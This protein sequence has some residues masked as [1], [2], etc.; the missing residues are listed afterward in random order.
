V[1]RV[2]I[3]GGTFDPVHTG[4]VVAAV[5]ARDRLGLDRV[6]VVVA[7]D[8]WQK[9]ER[10]LAPAADRFAMV[11]AAFEGLDRVEASDLELHRPGPTYTID[12]VVA[13]ARPDRELYLVLGRDAAVGV[14]SWR[15]APELRD[16]VT[17]AVVE[18]AGS[19][20]TRTVPAGWSTVS[21]TMP[22]LD[23]SSSDLRD[24]V[25]AGQAVDGLVPPGAVRIIRARRL[26]TPA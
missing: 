7:A 15:R 3:F 23:I 10:V 6:L 11:A 22:R 9:A 4:H 24:R 8:P 14:D 21:V 19:D 13:L 20:D 26:Y 18:R 2:G 17:V 1:E 25:R 16:L 5:E 12:T